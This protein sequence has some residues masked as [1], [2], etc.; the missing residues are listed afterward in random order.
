MAS[1]FW[2]PDLKWINAV[3]PTIGLM[4]T[5][6]SQ[7]PHSKLS[8]GN[9]LPG[10]DVALVQA[11]ASAAA[12]VSF[13]RAMMVIAADNA[14]FSITEVRWGLTAAISSRN[15]ATPLGSGRFGAMR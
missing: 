6:R 13:P 8:S 2:R 1:T 10:P 9:R 7:R 3:R 11:A 14:V 5:R 12:P 15:C 4:R